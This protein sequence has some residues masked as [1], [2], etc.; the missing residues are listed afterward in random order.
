MATATAQ[1]PASSRAPEA[2]VRKT[3]AVPCTKAAG[4]RRLT[5]TVATEAIDRDG[6]VVLPGGLLVD[7]YLKN[8]VMLWSHKYDQMAIG[9]CLALQLGRCGRELIGDF[10]FA[11]TDAGRD[12]YGLYKGEFLDAVSIGFKPL[13]FAPPT[14]EQLRARPDLAKCHRVIS[15]ALLQEI[16]AVPIPSNPDALLAAEAKGLHP[17]LATRAALLGPRSEAT[18]EEQLARALARGVLRAL[19]PASIADRVARTVAR[20]LGQG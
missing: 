11:D 12:A 9:R 3:H 2:P 1:P 15:E 18:T 5:I 10:D 20:Q 7:Q 13:K 14:Y 19:D 8:P 6:E 4:P 16:S 17:S